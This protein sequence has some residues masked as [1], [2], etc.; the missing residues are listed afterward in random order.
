MRC[1]YSCRCNYSDADKCN[2]LPIFTCTSP[3]S[4]R[5]V[6]DQI[7]L[8]YRLHPIT[9]RQDW[10]ASSNRGHTHCDTHV[11]R[12][13]SFSRICKGLKASMMLVFSQCVSTELKSWWVGGCYESTASFSC[14]AVLSRMA[15]CHAEVAKHVYKTIKHT[16]KHEYNNNKTRT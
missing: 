15:M 14:V 11:I 8:S 16:V 5:L 7:C 6:R 1:S 10:P 12:L 13:S 2:L 4:K 3:P 9:C